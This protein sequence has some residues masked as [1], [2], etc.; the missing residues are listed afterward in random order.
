MK[1]TT[2]AYRYDENGNMTADGNNTYIY[3]A[4]N[5][6]IKVINGTVK[7]EY[8][9]NGKAQ[10][11]KKTADGKTTLYHYDLA[12][13]LIEETMG[14]GTLIADYIYAGS[15][16][17]A[18]VNA[19]GDVFYYHND[20]LGTPLAMTNAQGNLVWKA[21]YDPFG[22][23][24]IDQS[25]TIINNFRFPGQYYDAESGLHYNWHRYYDPRTGRYMTA[26][27]IG[28]RGGLNR[29]VYVNAN[30][31]RFGDSRG[32]DKPG[33]SVD[34]ISAGLKKILESMP[35]GR[36]CC[37]VHDECYK[38]NQCTQNSWGANIC[39]GKIGPLVSKCARC[40]SN[41]T[42]CFQKCLFDPN[43]IPPGSKGE[44]Y[45]GQC[46]EY[47]NGYDPNDPNGPH[48]GHSTDP[49]PAPPQPEPPPPSTTTNTIP[50]G[51]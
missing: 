31:I 20:H 28:L 15:Y 32:L 17:I 24:Q 37:A 40:N 6:L 23:A 21:A 46:R 36:R 45:C 47:F 22:K 48:A 8:V 18:M 33:C 4:N 7:G 38:N 11:I 9:Y 44:Y 43:Y 42:N 14:D 19:S 49:V 12:G 34:G 39:L 41:V 50:H 25:S 29:Y 26:D 16:R 51:Y 5:Q 30:P 27:P 10:R 13:N 3:N 2:Q 1:S 35:C